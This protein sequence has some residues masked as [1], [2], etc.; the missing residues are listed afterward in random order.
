MLSNVERH[1]RSALQLAILAAALGL[2]LAALGTA[3]AQAAGTKTM[4]LTGTPAFGS[5]LLVVADVPGSLVGDAFDLWFCPDQTIFPTDGGLNNGD[6]VGPFIENQTGDSTT[7]VLTEDFFDD[8]S[9]V[10]G[11]FFIV[12]DYP[13]GN[14]SNWVGP[15]TCGSEP[16]V[17]P[18][19]LTC[20]PDPVVPGGT[21]TCVVTKGPAD[22]E[23][24]WNASFGGSA[25]AGQGVMLD[26]EGRGS[27]TFVVPRGA[28][29]QSVEVELVD[30]LRP[31]SVQ[32]STAALP[33][34]IPAGEGPAGV[35]LGLAFGALLLAGAAVVRMRRAGAVS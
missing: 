11:L 18:I 17:I 32:V 1:G 14:H 21:V 22:F 29:G 20:T 4:T 7:F 10:C 31:V 28:A 12:H 25:F 16:V 24:L 3:S 27:F 9:A 5:S 15:W 19:E 23:I 30:W 35:P 8:P 26:A 6:C 33:A 13:G 2:A 34:R